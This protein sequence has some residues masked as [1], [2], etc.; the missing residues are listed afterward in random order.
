MNI[1]SDNKARQVVTIT[2]FIR[3]IEQNIVH[4]FLFF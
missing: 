4:P 2:Y 1:L 3:E